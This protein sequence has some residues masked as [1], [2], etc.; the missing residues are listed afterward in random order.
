MS[1]WRRLVERPQQVWLRRA[2]FQV[3]LWLGLMLGVYVVMLSV[4]GS[5][6]VYRVE[7]HRLLSTQRPAYR[8]GA[9]PMTT[10][11]LRAAAER[12]YPGHAITRVGEE[13]S[14][15]D[16][17]I[18]IWVE[19]GGVTRERLFDPYT[20]EDLGNAITQGELGVI[21]LARLHDELLFDR[22]GKY[23]N[24]AGSAVFTLLVLTGAIVWW[25]G[26][27]R[28]RRSLTVGVRSGWK[29]INWDLHSAMGAWLFLFMLVWG[30]SGIYLGIPEPFSNFV[31]AVSDPTIDYGDRV[32][33]IVLLWLTWLHFGRWNNEWLKALWAVIGLVPAVMFVTG[34]VMWWQ[35]VVRPMRQRRAR[36]AIGPSP[37]RVTTADTA[38]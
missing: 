11:E 6:L 37:E 28:W 32:G 31:D 33:D 19:Q 27:A 29:R 2:I 14:R 26:I 20:G 16:P 7:L 3:H 36:T 12:A 5:A 24:G 38:T 22:T 10:E 4:T 23:V 30:V 15:R 8:P 35:R 18:E 21:W 17:T 25:P 34:L 1:A 13:F 9:M